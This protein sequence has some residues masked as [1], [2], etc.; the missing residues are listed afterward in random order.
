MRKD[1]GYPLP[2]VFPVLKSV[3]LKATENRVLCRDKGKVANSL[4]GFIFYF[5]KFVNTVKFHCVVITHL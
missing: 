5:N 1:A 3:A 4:R 2:S